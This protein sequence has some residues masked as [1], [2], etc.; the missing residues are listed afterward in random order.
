MFSSH[1]ITE[2]KHTCPWPGVGLVSTLVH[3]GSSQIFYGSEKLVCLSGLH[4]GA[5]PDG[6][7][8]T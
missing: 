2:V 3:T 4:V 6:Y 1:F 7:R 5:L 8:R